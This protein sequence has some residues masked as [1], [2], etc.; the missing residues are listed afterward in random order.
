M[1][2]THRRP[3]NTHTYPWRGKE[4]KHPGAKAS[5]GP[6]PQGATL[7]NKGD[8]DLSARHGGNGQPP[9]G[10]NAFTQ[11]SS[12]R[13]R[14]RPIRR[15]AHK[16]RERE[17]GFLFLMCEGGSAVPPRSQR[18]LGTSTPIDELGAR[19]PKGR[20]PR[21]RAGNDRRHRMLSRAPPTATDRAGQTIGEAKAP[22]QGAQSP[23]PA[24]ELGAPAQRRSIDQNTLS[25]NGQ[26]SQ[27]RPGRSGKGARHPAPCGTSST[28]LNFG[29]PP[30]S[31]A[32]TLPDAPPAHGHAAYPNAKTF[33]IV[34]RLVPVRTLWRASS[35]S[36]S[37]FTKVLPIP[38]SPFAT[39][40]PRPV[41]AARS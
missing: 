27:G 33:R 11:G 32:S 19:S 36:V 34:A 14:G 20:S 29:G 16:M 23:H 2:H 5:R 38:S 28:P 39:R 15:L 6:R 25:T 12:Q 22:E 24:A 3:R 9:F 4:R 31:V 37:H 8:G 7:F 18:R 41:P 13:A 10:A 26:W 1:G 30:R 40:D 21:H 17:G 35:Y